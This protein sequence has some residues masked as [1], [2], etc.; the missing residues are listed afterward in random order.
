MHLVQANI[1]AVRAAAV[2]IVKVED[3]TE[4]KGNVEDIS[5]K[6]MMTTIFAGLCMT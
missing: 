4:A 3:A 1:V 5:T 2:A 6:K